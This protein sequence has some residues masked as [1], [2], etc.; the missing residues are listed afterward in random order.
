MCAGRLRALALRAIFCPGRSTPATTKER[1][2]YTEQTKFL[3]HECL[4]EPQRALKL[5]GPLRS[6]KAA[7]VS[8]MPAA[9]LRAPTNLTDNSS[10]LDTRY[11]LIALLNFRPWQG[12]RCHGLL[13]S[14]QTGGAKD[15][16]PHMYICEHIRQTAT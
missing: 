6:Q 5:S 4:V 7:E 13:A 9:L 8:Q 16:E 14:E 10:I 12:E 1:D 15:L 2:A 11:D 3:F